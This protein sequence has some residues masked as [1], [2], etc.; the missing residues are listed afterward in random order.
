MIAPRLLQHWFTK[1]LAP[2]RFIREKYGHFKALLRLDNRALD[3]VADLDAHLYGHDPA[4]MA[5]IRFLLAELAEAVSGMAEHLSLMNPHPYAEVHSALER[6]VSKA[7]ALAA[8][9][10]KDVDPPYVIGLDEAAGHPGRAGGKA[11]NLSGARR[12]G[13]PTPQGFV[14]TASAFGRYLRD[15]NLEEEVERRFRSVSLADHGAIVRATGELQELILGAEVP[16]DI[17]RDILDAVRSCG[18]AGRRLAVRSSALAEDG[19]ISFAG[20][21]ASELNVASEDIFSAYKR[22]LAGKYCP[23]AVAYR[24]RHGLTDFD[25]AMAVLVLPMIEA[26]AAGVA[27]TRDP[28]CKAVGGDA[29]GIYVVGGLAAELVDGSA[30][31]A[32]HYLSRTPEPE[33]LMGCICDVGSAMPE[34]T[35]REIGRLAMSLERAFGEPQDV[36]WAL[37]PE[38]IVIL[39]TRRLQQ[40]PDQEF[41]STTDIGG[42]EAL[43]S[44]LDCASPGAACGPVHHVESGAGFRN[45]PAGSV[46]VT[47]SLRPAL[48]Q[49]L[50]RIAAIVASHGSRA[51]HLASVARERGVPVVVGSVPGLHEGKVVTV[52]AGA[53]KIYDRCLPGVTERSL[54]AQELLSRLRQENSE[55]AVLTVRL[56]LVDPEDESFSPQGLGSLHDVVRYCHEKGVAEMFSLVDRGGRGLGR[57]RRLATSLPLVMY[58]LDLGGGLSDAAG[59]RGAVEESH[60]ASKPLRALWAGLSDARIAWDSS[61][62]HVDWEE[63]DRVSAGIFS[64][65][66]RILASY[67]IVA[68]DYTHVNIRFGYHF[69]VVD[70]LCTDSPGSN[71]VKF[72]FKGGGAALAQRRYRL[73]FVQNVLERF[74]Y[75][76]SVRGDMLDAFHS[77]MPAA[78]TVR[79]LHVLGLVL[80]ETRLMDMKLSCA[81]DA[82][83]AADD[84]LRR[85]FPEGAV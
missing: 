19:R 71:Y 8:P 38:G 12:H 78:D 36:E 29:V 22:V 76:A 13:V 20:Q 15:N 28:A 27:Y 57:S 24:I 45:I 46:I 41:F 21:Y 51:S 54:T 25:T 77:R 9:E 59:G 58:V 14:V 40:D 18:F 23:R 75:E 67:A 49:F 74:G 66:S 11:A 68:P 65:D 16:P 17:A 84:F 48:S 63:F 53:G 4:D 37:G 26:R 72:R 83:T 43:A 61:Q 69:S 79:A 44:E 7:L 34:E 35:L 30:T 10:P 81:D 64:V 55:L 42:A 3:L 82:L 1:L 6:I 32:K 52:D 50:D 2:D 62:V 73:L 80:G 31:P 70:A 85:F 60:L 47:Q 56:N 5:R 39:Q 33:V